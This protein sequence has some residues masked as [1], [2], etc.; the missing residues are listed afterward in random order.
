MDA[1][2]Y[3]IEAQIE[4]THWWFVGRRK[5]FSRELLQ[6]NINHDARVLDVGTS[7]GTNLRMLRALGFR[8]V[9]GIDCSEEAIAFCHAKGLGPVQ[10]GDI[11]ALPFPDDSFDLVLATDVIEHVDDDA[12]ALREV[13]RVLRPGGKALITVPAFSSL[14]GLQDDKSFHKRRY[15]MPTLLSKVGAAGL[16]PNTYYYFNYLLFAPIWL[17]RRII[18]L[19]G[20]KLESENEI[21]TAT[22]NWILSKIFNFDIATARW[23]SPPFGVSAFIIAEKPQQGR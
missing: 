22:M 8:R 1:A 15:T 4:E 2:T 16:T 11:C 6:A 9:T 12:R 20:L 10:L 14:W 23:I 5:L 19:S 13:L 18:A 3:A 7:T 17:A 21:N